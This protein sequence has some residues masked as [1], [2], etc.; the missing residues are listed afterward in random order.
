M[1]SNTERLDYLHTSPTPPSPSLSPS[2]CDGGNS[3]LLTPRGGRSRICLREAIR[4]LLLLIVVPWR[5][6]SLLLALLLLLGLLL[7]GLLLLRRNV[8]GLVL[9]GIPS[10]LILPWPGLVGPSG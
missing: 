1:L 4:P 2:S 7:L 8:L 5:S 3:G 6:A 10:L 9:A